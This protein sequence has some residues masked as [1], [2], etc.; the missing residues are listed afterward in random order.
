MQAQVASLTADDKAPICSKRDTVREVAKN[1]IRRYAVA[2]Y[3]VEEFAI[4][5]WCCCDAQHEMMVRQRR[6]KITTFYG[7]KCQVSFSVD[8]LYKEI[9]QEARDADRQAEK[10]VQQTLW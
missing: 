3:A 8:E 9:Q 4:D 6:I 5:K 7:Q 2:G 1:F 10:P